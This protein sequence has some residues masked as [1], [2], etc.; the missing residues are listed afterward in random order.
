M[1]DGITP[2]QTVGPYFAYCL[3]PKDYDTR[4][5]FSADLTTPAIGGDRI[6]VVGQVLDGDGVGIGDAMIEIWQADPEGR[7]AHPADDRARGNSGFAG[8]GRAPTTPDGMYA[9]TT[10][11]P[12]QV[13]GPNGKPQAPHIAVTVFARG[14]LK[15]LYTRIY[16]EDES[17]NAA[18]PILALVPDE[19]ARRTLIARRLAGEAE[20][21]YRFDIRLQGEGETVFFEA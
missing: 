7:Y 16:F 4:E 19:E 20:P 12:G 15:H 21:T 13:P 8:F 17:A 18:D 14:M 1:T 2:S 10:V 6:R 11:K 5:I 9:F 3:T